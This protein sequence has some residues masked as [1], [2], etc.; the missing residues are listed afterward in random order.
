MERKRK[1]YVAK[2]AVIMGSVPFLIWAY[3]F[4]PDAG[5]SGVPGESG[6]CATLGCHTGTANTGKGSV[7]VAFAGGNTYTPGVTQHLVV[8]IADPAATQKLWG[9]QL[10]AR[11]SS[12]NKSMAGTFQSTDQFT[13]LIK[14]QTLQR[15]CRV[16]WRGST[17]I[18]VRFT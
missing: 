15:R 12:N 10:T 16:A 9:F 5:Y 1:L 18:G 7:T 14:H 8:T 11:L 3:E 4:G 6:S 17:R 13:L 2:A